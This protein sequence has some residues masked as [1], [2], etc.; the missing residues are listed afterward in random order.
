MDFSLSMLMV[1]EIVDFCL[2]RNWNRNL[3]WLKKL[4]FDPNYRNNKKIYKINNMR[5]KFNFKNIFDV[6]L[7]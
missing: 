5:S 1:F 4:R 6:I 2:F 7:Y 3:T